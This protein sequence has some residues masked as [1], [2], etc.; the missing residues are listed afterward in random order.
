[1]QTIVHRHLK[2]VIKE[3]KRC[4]RQNRL[5]GDNPNCPSSAHALAVADEQ[6]RM[7][8]VLQHVLKD[9]ECEMVCMSS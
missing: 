3:L 5:D 6:K 1:M 8:R 4:E 7:I 2:P 9:V